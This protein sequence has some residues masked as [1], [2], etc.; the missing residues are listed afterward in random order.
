MESLV[1]PADRLLNVWF[2]PWAEWLT[3]PSGTV[4]ELHAIS[5]REGHLE[6]DPQERGITVYGWPGATLR[7]SVSGQLVRDF[8]IPFPDIPAGMDMKQFV[9][10]LFGPPPTTEEVQ[11]PLRKKEPWWRFW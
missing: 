5:P 6:I 2:E 7:V 1:V 8:D 10:F 4:V 9:S 11:G 3:F